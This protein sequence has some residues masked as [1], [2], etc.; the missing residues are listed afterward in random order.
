[1]L[2]PLVE[3]LLLL[4]ALEEL[5]SLHALHDDE[6]APLVVVRVLVDVADV[7]DVLA[8]AGAPVQLDL[9]PRLGIILKHLE[10]IAT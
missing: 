1:M 2:T 3:S 8:A 9:P 10:T 4:D 6:E 7:D 5:P